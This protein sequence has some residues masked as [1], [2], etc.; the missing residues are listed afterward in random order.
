MESENLLALELQMVYLK[1]MT[2]QKVFQY[3]M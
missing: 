2:Q 1:E 3:L